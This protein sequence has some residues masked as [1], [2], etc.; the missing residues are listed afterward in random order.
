MNEK[1]QNLLNKLSVERDD[2]LQ[3]LHLLE[4]GAKEEW[5]KAEQKWGNLQGRLRDTG[6]K[7]QLE[8]KEEIHD[9][10]EEVDKLQ[11][12]VT[13]KVTDL[14]VEIVEEMHELSEELSELY[15]KIR[16]HF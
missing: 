1:L 3:G 4:A 11:H 7:W 2:F 14:K 13:D 10:G 9:L 15:Q 8:A 5:E 12:K 16:R 6:Y